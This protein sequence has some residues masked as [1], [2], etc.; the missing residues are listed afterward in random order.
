MKKNR[1]V[2][3]CLAFFLLAVLP[4]GLIISCTEKSEDIVKRKTITEVIMENER[5]SILKDIMIHAKMTDAL[6]TGEITFFAPDNSAFG[7]ANIFSSNVITALPADSAIK[8]INNHIVGKKRLEYKDLTV[9]KEKSITGKELSL[10]VK[11]SIFAVNKADIIFSNIS[12][13]N[14]VIHIIDSLAVR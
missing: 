10:T 5:F 9:A 13:A 1:F 14:G 11:D 6:R 3:R 2:G 4:S 8:L 7:K 12:A